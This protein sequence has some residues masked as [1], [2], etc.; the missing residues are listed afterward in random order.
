MHGHDSHIPTMS[1]HLREHLAEQASNASGYSGEFHGNEQLGAIAYYQHG[2][3]Q[4]RQLHAR[5]LE[6]AV[7][8][9]GMTIEEI[10]G[11]LAEHGITTSAAQ[12]CDAFPQLVG[13]QRQVRWM[14]V[15]AAVY[16]PL[17]HQVSRIVA[18][19]PGLVPWDQQH[20]AENAHRLLAA[21]LSDTGWNGE[22]TALAH[23]DRWLL[24]M[25][26]PHR[27]PWL[28]QLAVDVVTDGL[29]QQ[30]VNEL[31]QLVSGY[32]AAGQDVTPD[33]ADVDRALGDP[34]ELLRGAVRGEPQD[35]IPLHAAE[36]A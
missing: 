10:A 14:E 30:P 8:H 28:S 24:M 27:Q 33:A 2:I 29:A 26:A 34:V 36:P 31:R 17:L 20:D 35:V 16:L 4:A 3:N 32:Y 5:A 1:R 6:E 25:Y 12:L 11:G 7:R 19:W 22:P 18:G 9:Q 13:M 23:C 21:S 15:N